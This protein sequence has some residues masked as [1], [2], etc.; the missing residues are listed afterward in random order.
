MSDIRTNREIF[1]LNSKSEFN[2]LERTKKLD[3]IRLLERWTKLGVEFEVLQKE[4]AELKHQINV[5]R[6]RLRVIVS[7]LI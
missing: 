7:T 6:S 2:D 1:H 5:T 3:L 4:N